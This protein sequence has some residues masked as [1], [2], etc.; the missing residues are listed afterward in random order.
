[1]HEVAGRSIAAHW[2]YKEDMLH[3]KRF[4]DKIAWLRQLMEWRQDVADADEFVDGMKSDVFHDRV[5]VFTPQGD[6]IDLPAG[7]TPIDF[8]RHPPNWA[9]AVAGRI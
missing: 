8:P 4:Q 2:Q 9:I 5:Y 1:M 3:D 6:V 7:S